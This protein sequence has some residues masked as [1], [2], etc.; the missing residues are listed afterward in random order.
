MQEQSRVAQEMDQVLVRSATDGQA[1]G[2]VAEASAARQRWDQRHT[3]AGAEGVEAR[4]NAA[5]ASL[6]A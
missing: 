4:A 6:K 3:M 1:M 5:A 2:T